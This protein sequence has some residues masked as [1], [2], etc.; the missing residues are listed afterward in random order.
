VGWQFWSVFTPASMLGA[1]AVQTTLEQIDIV[2]RM[3][4]AYSDTFEMAYCA[5]DVMRIFR[6]GKIASMC[7]IEV[8]MLL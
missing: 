6:S 1:E 4:D 7:G 2:H 5:A 3:V 8:R